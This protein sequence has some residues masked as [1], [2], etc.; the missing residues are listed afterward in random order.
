MY[1]LISSAKLNDLDPETYV[2]H[3]LSRIAEHPVNHVVED[4]LLWNLAG[5][6]S[7]AAVGI[8]AAPT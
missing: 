8:S 1:S 6:A 3:V 7:S 2:R 5:A 4:L